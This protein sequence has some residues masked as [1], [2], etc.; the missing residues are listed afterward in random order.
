MK[1]H[2]RIQLEGGRLQAKGTGLRRSQ[3]CS[4]LD[5]GLAA[6]RTMRKICFCCLSHSTCGILFWQLEETKCVAL[7]F[8]LLRRKKARR[9]TWSSKMGTQENQGKEEDGGFWPPHTPLLGGLEFALH[10][11]TN[12]FKDIYLWV[13]QMFESVT[14]LLRTCPLCRGGIPSCLQ[15][16]SCDLDPRLLFLLAACFGCV[17]AYPSA[18]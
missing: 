14:V 9:E 7:F 11:C 13:L 8:F 18:F 1:D 2:V 16:A 3:P 17:F 15:C 5:L 10:D 4:H 12:T 6:S